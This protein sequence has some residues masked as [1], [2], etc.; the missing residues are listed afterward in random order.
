MKQIAFLIFLILAAS[1]FLPVQANAEPKGDCFVLKDCCAK[2]ENF[3][4]DIDTL[5]IALGQM[6]SEI[7]EVKKNM[8]QGVTYYNDDAISPDKGDVFWEYEWD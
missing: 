8:V 1:F 2:I 3:I 5:G 7:K 6:E 4:V